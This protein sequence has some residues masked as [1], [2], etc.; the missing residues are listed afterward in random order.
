MADVLRDMA[1]TLPLARGHKSIL[2]N[3]ARLTEALTGI[4]NEIDPKILELDLDACDERADRDAP[5][6]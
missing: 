5:R 1:E 6:V 2:R 4:V 3:A